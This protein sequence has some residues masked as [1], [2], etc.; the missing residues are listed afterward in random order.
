M[1]NSSAG[2]VLNG[3][4][5]D[6]GSPHGRIIATILLGI[7]DFECELIQERICPDIAAVEAR[8]TLWPPARTAAEIGPTRFQHA[9]PHQAGA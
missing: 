2:T 9:R 3:M 7:A 4:A 8:K 5:I 6:L 1:Q